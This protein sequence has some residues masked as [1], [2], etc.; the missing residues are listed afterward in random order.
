MKIPGL[1]SAYQGDKFLQTPPPTSNRW[2]ASTLSPSPL[3]ACR[4]YSVRLRQSSQ[5]SHTRRRGVGGYIKPMVIDAESGK[6][7]ASEKGVTGS[8][9]CASCMMV[10]RNSAF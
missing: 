10:L 4:P 1:S 3:A 2:S 7:S 9:A 6:D 8:L 5:D